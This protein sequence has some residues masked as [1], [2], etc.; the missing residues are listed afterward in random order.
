MSDVDLSKI[1]ERTIDI[2]VHVAWYALW[3]ATKELTVPQYIVLHRLPLVINIGEDHCLLF[4][5]TDW[6]YRLNEH[7]AWIIVARTD[8]WS[9]DESDLYR[10]L[11]EKDGWKIEEADEDED[12][13]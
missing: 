10:K 13:Y 8:S 2:T 4:D 3:Q 6:A 7:P 11:L 5:S 12:E 9:D 1:G